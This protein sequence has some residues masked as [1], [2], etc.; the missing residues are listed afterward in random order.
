MLYLSEASLFLLGLVENKSLKNLTTTIYVAFGN[1]CSYNCKYCAQNNFK[2]NNNIQKISRVNW[3]KV[4]SEDFFY[5]L[6][7]NNNVNR[8][9]FQVLGSWEENFINFF[10]ENEEKLKRFKI[11]VCAR[12]TKEQI[13]NLYNSTIDTICLA[14]DEAVNLNL[15]KGS[16]NLLKTLLSYPKKEKLR[17]H[18]I[19]GLGETDL[20][21]LS[22]FSLLIKNG[23]NTSIFAFTPVN[24]KLSL[25]QPE[26]LKWRLIQ[27]ATY[28]INFNLPININFNGENIINISIPDK[29]IIKKAILTR[30]CSF[31]NR[32]FY[33]EKP[34]GFMYNYHR[35]LKEDE[36]EKELNFLKEVIK[37][38]H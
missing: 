37:W 13:D 29:S 32:P 36:F 18:L 17:T 6:E 34:R 28:C 15:R 10:L 7:K 23:I 27:I 5:A 31:C 16:Q 30:G 26:P 1:K 20:E 3:K 9:C 33:N 25:S 8:I 35:K 4:T 38:Q 12:L 19:Y 14:I 22:T 21:F 11:S 24:D 2:S